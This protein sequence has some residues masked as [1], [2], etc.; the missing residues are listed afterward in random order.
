[1]VKL[2]K[3]AYA[4]RIENRKTLLLHFFLFI[5]IKSEST[6]QVHQHC[7]EWIVP[8]VVKMLSTYSKVCIMINL[9]QICSA[10]YRN[11]NFAHSVND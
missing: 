7:K 5:G 10:S 4:L 1:M 11:Y 8:I 3:N 2:P 9:L 6:Y